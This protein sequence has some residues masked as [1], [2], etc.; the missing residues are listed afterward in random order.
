MIN[1]PEF[2][3]VTSTITPASQA[4]NDQSMRTIDF[5]GGGRGNNSS[6]GPITMAQ[7]SCFSFGNDLMPTNSVSS[8]V[9]G[10]HTFRLKQLE[11]WYLI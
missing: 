8:I 3:I 7:P 5:G 1:G 9:P 4:N 2:G 10:H 6:A 11:V